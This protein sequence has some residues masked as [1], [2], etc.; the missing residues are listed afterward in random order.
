MALE[1]KILF[2]AMKENL[3]LGEHLTPHEEYEEFTESYEEVQ[4][5]LTVIK[6]CAITMNT[7]VKSTY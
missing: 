2:V 3:P 1:Q 4:K 5:E 7:F 6:F